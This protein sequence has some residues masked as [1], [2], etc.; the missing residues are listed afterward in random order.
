MVFTIE[1]TLIGL[2]IKCALC[3]VILAAANTSGSIPP[4]NLHMKAFD[5]ICASPS[6]H[7]L[8]DGGTYQVRLSLG[9]TAEDRGDEA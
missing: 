6:S 3:G 9:I 7:A 2:S 1:L 8:D 5:A 4:L